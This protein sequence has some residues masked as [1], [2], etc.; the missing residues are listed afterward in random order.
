MRNSIKHPQSAPVSLVA[1]TGKN[2]VINYYVVANRRL[3]PLVLV[4]TLAL[5]GLFFAH[6]CRG[7]G[8]LRQSVFGM[9]LSQNLSAPKSDGFDRFWADGLYICQ[10]GVFGL[11]AKRALVNPDL[12]CSPAYD[13]VTTR[14]IQT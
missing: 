8:C 13:T 14:F 3:S 4:L 11:R 2:L 1:T 12:M 5:R 10:H 9:N 7:I 6:C